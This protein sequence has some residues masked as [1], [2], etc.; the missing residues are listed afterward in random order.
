MSTRKPH[1][2][3][4]DGCELYRILTA[5]GALRLWQT[6]Y[7]D[8]D[9]ESCARFEAARLGKPVPDAMLPNGHLLRLPERG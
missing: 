1:C 7:C 8:D 2:S 3:H 5:A 9:Y 4:K 6:R